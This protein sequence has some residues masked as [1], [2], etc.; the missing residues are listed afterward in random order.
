MVHQ[1]FGLWVAT[2][3]PH[4]Q[5]PRGLW[6]QGGS[7]AGNNASSEGRRGTVQMWY[8]QSSGWNQG[9]RE[10]TASC[11]NILWSLSSS[12]HARAHKCTPSIKPPLCSVAM[13]TA[14]SPSFFFWFR[15]AHFA[16]CDCSTDQ[17][18]KH[19]SLFM[20]Y[21][22]C[23]NVSFNNS[24]GKKSNLHL[25]ECWNDEMITGRRKILSYN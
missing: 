2:I 7:Q 13:V 19:S 15:P 4:V 10:G 23:L 12:V 16:P 8:L 14:I 6:N 1:I 17:K 9:A 25:N 11:V 18:R 22:I 20:G 24:Q 5:S 3:Q 21:K